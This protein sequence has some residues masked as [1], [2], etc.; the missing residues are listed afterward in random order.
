VTVALA[1]EALMLKSFT[2]AVPLTLAVLPPGKLSTA[3]LPSE[4]GPASA[5]VGAVTVTV[6]FPAELSVVVDPDVVVDDVFT[7]PRLQTMLPPVAL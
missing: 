1:G 4:N 2:V 7:V 3:L 5:L 6:T